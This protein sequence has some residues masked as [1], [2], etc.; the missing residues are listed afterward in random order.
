VGPEPASGHAFFSVATNDVLCDANENPVVSLEIWPPDERQLLILPAKAVDGRSFFFCR[1]L[2]LYP[3]Q[4][5][6]DL[7]LS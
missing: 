2:E 4:I 7:T 5:E 3:L 1:Y 6:P